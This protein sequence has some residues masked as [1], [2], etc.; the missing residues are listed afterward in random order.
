MKKFK[1]VG[2]E[3]AKVSLSW[4]LFVHFDVLLGQVIHVVNTCRVEQSWVLENRLRAHHS[5]TPGYLKCMFYVWELGDAAVD[6][7][8][9]FQCL[10]YFLYYRVVSMHDPLFVVFF[11][12]S[13]HRQKRCSRFFYPLN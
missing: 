7:N 6:N 5:I 13:V 1:H 3:T 2:S 4:V 8:R 11:Q 9:D 12:A 10:F